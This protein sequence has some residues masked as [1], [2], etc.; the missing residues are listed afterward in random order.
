MWVTEA[1]LLTRMEKQG[2]EV[3]REDG[4]LLWVTRTSASQTRCHGACA[5]G[6]WSS[7]AGQGGSVRAHGCWHRH[8]LPKPCFGRCALFP[9][10]VLAYLLSRAAAQSLG[11][12]MFWCTARWYILPVG[13]ARI[14][15]L[16][17]GALHPGP[18]QNSALSPTAAAVRCLQEK[19]KNTA[20]SRCRDNMSPH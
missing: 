16:T 2:R 11:S 9:G 13:W 5:V 10:K 17:K 19:Y 15:I 14:G 1:A 12:I 7:N 18:V 6:W 3:V 20:A 4:I 8:H